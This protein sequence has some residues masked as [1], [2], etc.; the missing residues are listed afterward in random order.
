MIRSYARLVGYQRLAS[1]SGAVM[2]STNN[3]DGGRGWGEGHVT[4][5]QPCL[6]SVSHTL[7]FS[8]ASRA[9][10]YVHQRLA[11]V[12][13][14]LN[15]PSTS[16]A[17]CLCI[18]THLYEDVGKWLKARLQVLL[19]PA[20]YVSSGRFQATES[21]HGSS[22][23]KLPLHFL[24]FSWGLSSH[25]YKAELRIALNQSLYKYFDVNH[26]WRS[27]LLPPAVFNERKC[28]KERDTVLLY[29]RLKSMQA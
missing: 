27:L 1:S 28:R 23:D 13:L 17:T 21:S 24:Y 16:T 6:F 19:A 15:T 20:A 7:S 11:C 9:W 22:K 18:Y 25:N 14:P 12:L 4:F 26:A 8:I 29:K 3:R 5:S 2:W 10:C